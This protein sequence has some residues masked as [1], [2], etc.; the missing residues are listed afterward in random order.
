MKAPRKHLA[1][2]EQCSALTAY[3]LIFVFFFQ[4]SAAIAN[5]IIV[6]GRTKT[7]VTTQGAK[8]D[9]RT[10]TVRGASGFN[11]FREFDVH[12]NKTVDLHLP[13][14]TENL[15]NMVYDKRSN[16]EGA[17]NSV[18]DGS[19]GGNLI[20]VNPYGLIVGEQGSI[21]VGNLS[22][23]TP[24]P[25]FMNELINADGVISDARTQQ[26]M[27]GNI[28]LSAS[29]LITVKGQINAQDQVLLH[30]ASIDV[31]GRV[32]V[33]PAVQSLSPAF[34]QLVNVDAEQLGA[35]LV[36]NNGVIEIVA[37]NNIRIDGTLM[38]DGSDQSN[39]GSVVLNAGKDIELNSSTLISAKGQ[40]GLSD[41][42]VVLS[43]AQ[44]DAV[45]K[46]GAVIDV[47]SSAASGNGGFAEFSAKKSLRIENAEFAAHATN[48]KSGLVYLDPEKME[49]AGLKTSA[50]S[51]LLIEAD[52]LVVIEEGAIV[53]SRSVDSDHV[54]GASTADSG[55]IVIRAPNIV[56]E[57]QAQILAHSDSAAFE[58]GDVTLTNLRDTEVIDNDTLDDI[59]D[60]L[61]LEGK[62]IARLLN[63][64]RDA[65]ILVGVTKNAQSEYVEGTGAI[66]KGKDV[67]IHAYASDR[68][69]SEDRLFGKRARANVWLHNTQIE[70]ESI[71]VQAEA[72]T[73]LIPELFDE[74]LSVGGFE[75][76]P[77]A[78]VENKI[79]ALGIPDSAFY[80]KTEA[81]ADTRISGDNT[82]LHSTGEMSI[83]AQA[84]NAANPLSVG[85]YVG[86]EIIEAD[87]TATVSVE[88]QSVLRSDSDDFT[89]EASSDTETTADANVA[90]INKKIEIALALTEIES[91][92][93]VTLSGEGEIEAE[94][95][96]VSATSSSEVENTALANSSGGDSLVTALSISDVQSTAN[97]QANGDI[98]ADTLE[99]NALVEAESNTSASGGAKG[100]PGLSDRFTNLQNAS[101]ALLLDKAL[102]A[103]NFHNSSIPD[104]M[105]K[106]M[107]DGKFNVA[108]AITIADSN[109]NA[110]ALLGPLTHANVQNASNITAHVS[111]EIQIGADVASSSTGTA[112]GGAIT[113]GNYN[114]SSNA[115]ILG[116]A[117]LKAG[118]VNV[119]ATTEHPYPWDFDYRS[120]EE[121]YDKLTG[122]IAGM[123]FNGVASNKNK[124]KGSGAAASV[125]S[126]EYNSNANAAIEDGAIVRLVNTGEH[127][128]NVE[129][130]TDT[131][132]VMIAGQDPRSTGSNAIGGS[133]NVVVLGGEVLAS[134]G[135]ADISNDDG[136]GTLVGDLVNLDINAQTTNNAIVIT[137][138]GGT[139]DR[140][141][142]NGTVGYVKLDKQTKVYV[143]PAA[144]ISAQILSLNA[145]T[146][147]GIWNIA[148][149]F[150]KSGAAGVGVS[151]AINDA[152][153][154]TTSMIGDDDDTKPASASIHT[155][156]VA[157]EARAKGVL[158]T[159]S[160]A[161][162]IVSSSDEK[163]TGIYQKYKDTKKKVEG[164]LVSATDFVNSKRSTASQDGSGGDNSASSK[165]SPKPSYGVA[166]S[167]AASVNQ[168]AF[169]THAGVQ[170]AALN[171]TDLNTNAINSVDLDA[172]AG[173]ASL[174]KAKSSSTKTSAAFAGAFASNDMDNRT[175]ATIDNATIDDVNS[176][177]LQALSGGDQTAVGVGMAVNTSSSS[178][179][180]ASIAGSVS[181]THSN[182]QTTSELTGNS[183]MNGTANL[184]SS[185]AMTA[186]DQSQ[187]HAG[188]GSLFYG[189][190]GG[191]GAAITF[192]EIANQTQAIIDHATVQNLH[193]VSVKSI[194]AANISSGAAMAG[195]GSS[196]NSLA[197]SFVFNEINNSNQ[198]LIENGTV[199]STTDGD[200][201]ELVA[202]DQKTVSA[203]DAIIDGRDSDSD[204]DNNGSTLSLNNDE[205]N[206]IV[207]VAG[208]VQV[209]KNNV[210]VSLANNKISNT[211][212]VVVGISKLAADTVSAEAKTKTAINAVAVGV[213]GGTSS[214]A[215]NGSVALSEIN[216]QTNVFITPN[217]V[218][219]PISS[220]AQADTV[221]ASNNTSL[222]ASDESDIKSLAGNLSFSAKTAIGAAVSVSEISN[223]TKTQAQGVT[224]LHSESLMASAANDSD[225]E[226]L[227]ASGGGAGKVAI[228]AS[229]SVNEIDNQTIAQVSDSSFA[230][231]SQRLQ[232]IANDESDI[233]SLAGTINGAGKAAGGAAVSVNTIGNSTQ[234]WISDL[235]H[236]SISDLISIDAA[237]RANIDSYAVA[238]GG[239]GTAAFNGS[240]SSN[241]ISN[242]TESY[243]SNVQQASNSAA[244]VVASGD[245]STI[246]S[247]AGNVGFA[248]SAAVGASVAVNRISNTTSAYVTQNSVLKANNVMVN[249]F[250]SAETD[251]I[252]VGVSASAN[253]GIA[254]SVVVNINDSSVDAHIDG[255][256][257]VLAQHNVAVSAQSSDDI[258]VFAGALGIGVNGAGAGASV[259]VNQITSTTQAYISGAGTQ[260]NALANSATG[261]AV[262]NGISDFDFASEVSSVA[263]AAENGEDGEGSTD[264][265]YEK[266]ALESKLNA[267]TKATGVIVN[268]RSMQNVDSIGATAGVGFYAGI[269]ATGNVNILGGETRAYVN[270]ATLN[271]VAGA[272]D[273]QS[274]AVVAEDHTYTNAVVGAIGGGAAGIGAAVDTVIMERETLASIQNN[275][276]VNSE[277]NTKINAL[278]S[279]G[280]NSIAVGGA[281]GGAAL[282][283]SGSVLKF[284]AITTAQVEQSNL[285]SGSI[286]VRAH[287]QN[288]SSF[289]D[290]AAALASGSAGSGTFAVNI[291][292]NQTHATVN[293]TQATP[294]VLKSAGAVNVGAS[295]DIDNQSLVISFAGGAGAAGVAG[296][297]VVNLITSDTA[298]EVT[299]ATI[300]SD[301]DKVDSLTLSATDAIS[302]DSKAGAAG[303]SGGAGIG[304][305]ATVNIVKNRVRADMVNAD[306]VTENSGFVSLIAD[307]QKQADT[308]TAT[309]GAGLTVGI[310]GAALVNLFGAE[311]TG[312]AA[313]ELDNGGDG[314]LSTV[315]K[316]TQ[317][318]KSDLLEGQSSNTIT[319]QEL[320]AIDT[321][322]QTEVKS[323][324]SSAPLEGQFITRT[325]ITGA[326]SSVTT[327][328]L[329]LDASDQTS[330]EST[331]GGFAAG[332]VGFGGAFALTE[333]NNNLIAEVGQGVNVTASSVNLNAQ[334]DKVSGE[335]AVIDSDVYAGAAG[336]VGAGAAIALG[337]VNNTVLARY[338]GNLNDHSPS[339][340]KNA[341]VNI[342]AQDSS[343]VLTDAKGA[344]AG[345]AAA[346]IV[347]SESSKQSAVVAELGNGN[348]EDFT[349]LK[350]EA[351]TEGNIHTLAQAAAG[352]L[353]GSGAGASALAEESTEVSVEVADSANI[354]DQSGNVIVLAQADADVSADADGVAVA[355][356]LG[357]GVSTAEAIQHTQVKVDIGNNV[358]IDVNRLTA[359]AMLNQSNIHADA[360]AVGG[361]LLSGSSA[362]WAKSENLSDTSL[363]IGNLAS[364]MTQ[365]GLSLM[366]D[367]QAV[368]SASVD[369]ANGG[370]VAVGA[371]QSLVLNRA[372]SVVNIGDSTSLNNA[373][374][375]DVILA[376]KG[377]TSS[378][379][380]SVSGSG[381]VVSGVSTKATTNTATRTQVNINSDSSISNAND[382]VQ[383][384]A[385]QSNQINSKVD[386]INA[387]LV[388]ASGALASNMVDSEVGLSLSKAAIEAKRISL[389]ANN[390]TLKHWLG[391]VSQTS[392][393]SNATANVNSGSGGVVDAPAAR[394]STSILH[395]TNID[396]ADE[397]Q[398]LA[399]G[400][401]NS[402]SNTALAVDVLNTIQAKDKVVL[403]SGG[404]IAVAKSS[405]KI[406]STI[407]GGVQIDDSK[408]LAEYGQLALGTRNDVAIY[409]RA[410]ADTYGLAGA[411]E[412]ISVASLAGDQGITIGSGSELLADHGQLRLTAGQNSSGDNSS[413]DL[414]SKVNL[415]NKTAIPMDTDPDA[416][417]EVSLNSL[418]DVKSNA[419]VKASDDIYLIATDGDVNLYAYGLGKD[420]YRETLAKVGSAISNAF[421][422]GDVNFDITSSTETDNTN[423]T[424]NIDGSIETSIHRDQFIEI[425][426]VKNPASTD[427]IVDADGTVTQ[428]VQFSPDDPSNTKLQ[429]LY[430]KIKTS[431]EVGYESIERL[432][433]ADNLKQRMEKL[434]D[435][436]D[437]YA[438]DSVSFA[439]YGNEIDF[440]Q[441]QLVDM[442]LGGFD[443]KGDY[444]PGTLNTANKLSPKAQLQIVQDDN[445]AQRTDVNLEIDAKTADQTAIVGEIATV[446]A[447]KA[448][449]ERLRD[450]EQGKLDAEN[451]KDEADRD[452]DLI[453]EY[454]TEIVRLNDDIAEKD[455]ELGVLNTELGVV[456][457]ELAGLEN[458]KTSIQSNIDTLQAQIVTASDT[459]ISGPEAD[460][461][462]VDSIR[463]DLGNIIVKADNLTGTGSIKA[464]NDASISVSN[465]APIHLTLNDL[466]INDQ[467]GNITFNSYL[468]DG[469]NDVKAINKSGNAPGFTASNFVTARSDG[470]PEI[471]ITS[472]YNPTAAPYKSDFPATAPDIYFG[473]KDNEER[474]TIW[475]PEGRFTATSAAGSL[476]FEY[477]DV[478]A[479]TV[480]LAAENG[481]FV[482]SYTDN[483]YHVGGEPITVE[484]NKQTVGRGIFANGDILIS[485]RY[486]NINS[487]I[488]SGRE[489]WQLDI[490]SAP[491]VQARI[492]GN[493]SFVTESKVKS[494][495]SGQGASVTYIKDD[496]GKLVSVEFSTA[497]AKTYYDTYK[498]QSNASEFF[499]LVVANDDT[500][501][502]AFDASSD[503]IVV[504]GVEVS[505]GFIQLFGQLMNTSNDS[506]KLVVLDGYG[507]VQIDNQSG[508]NLELSNISTGRGV[509]GVIDI[510]D[511]VSVD[512]DDKPVLKRTI[513]ERLNGKVYQ[514]VNSGSATNVNESGLSYAPKAGMEFVLTTAQDQSSKFVYI[515]KGTSLFG[516]IK[517][518]EGE[519]KQYLVSSTPVGEPVALDGGRYLLENNTG[520]YTNVK[521]KTETKTT[522]SEFTYSE[523]SE[524]NWW[525]LCTVQNVTITARETRG[526]TVV[527]RNSVYAS[528]PI[529]I[530][531]IGD[532]SGGDVSVTSNFNSKVDIA[533]SI[534]NENGVTNILA[535]SGEIVQ[536]DETSVLQTGALNLVAKNDIYRDADATR[537]QVR[538][539][540][541]VNAVSADGLIR[542]EQQQGDLQVGSIVANNLVE[543]KS[544]GA[545]QSASNASQVKADRINLVASGGGIGESADDRLTIAAG[546]TTESLNDAFG[547]SIDAVDGI[548]LEQVASDIN[549]GGHLL[550]DKVKSATG[551]IDLKAHGTFIDNNPDERVD[552]A[553]QEQ[554]LAFW[555]STA[556]IGDENDNVFFESDEFSQ[557]IDSRDYDAMFAS[558]EY[559]NLST[560]GKKQVQ[561]LVSEERQNNNG[562][563]Q[564]WQ[565]RLEQA[566]PDTYNENYRYAASDVEIANLERQWAREGVDSSE[567][568]AR[569][570]QYEDDRT[571]QYH[572]LHDQVG[573]LNNGVYD[574]D[575]VYQLS[576]D[577]KQAL[578]KGSS[579]TEREL[580]LALSPGLIKDVTD[581]NPILKVA[582]VSGKS[583]RLESQSAGIG[584]QEVQIRIPGNVAVGTLSLSQ[585]LALASAE[586]GDIRYEDDDIIITRRRQVNLDSTDTVSIISH[587]GD[588]YVGSESDITIAEIVAD[589]EARIKA[590]GTIDTEALKGGQTAHVTAESIILE[591]AQGGI[592]NATNSVLIDLINGGSLIAR[593]EGDLFVKETNG[594]LSLD[595][596]YS[597]SEVY[598]ESDANIIDGFA[599]DDINLIG[600]GIYL[601]ANNGSIGDAANA[602]DIEAS[603]NSLLTA[604]ALHN[605]YLANHS[606]PLNIDSITAGNI[607]GLDVGVTG[608]AI[609]TEISAGK[610]V[611]ITGDGSLVLLAP[612]GVGSQ[613]NA[614]ENTEI[615]IEGNLL[616]EQ[617]SAIIADNLTL[618]TGGQVELADITVSEDLN[619]LSGDD[620]TLV[621]NSAIQTSGVSSIRS[622]GA[623]NSAAGSSLLSGGA[624]TLSALGSMTLSQIMAQ[625]LSVDGRSSVS[626]NNV[627]ILNDARISAQGDMSLNQITANTL[628]ADSAAAIELSTIAVT[629]GMTLVA[630]DDV[631]MAQAQVG[632]LD[633]TAGTAVSLDEVDVAAAAILASQGD[634]SLNQITANT[635]NADS[636]AAIEL[637]TIAVTEG[638]TLVAAD[639]VMMAQAQVG[640][641][642]VT[643]G[644]AVSLDEVDVAAAAILAS[645]GDMSLNQI[646]ANTLNADSAAAIELSTIAVTK[647]VTLVS[648]LTMEL[649]DL[650]AQSITATSQN[651]MNLTRV[652]IQQQASFDAS[653]DLAL[654]TVS[655][656]NADILGRAN[657]ALTDVKVVDTANVNSAQQLSMNDV[658][659]AS[660][661]ANGGSTIT[662]VNATISSD[663]TINAQDNMSLTSVSAGQLMLDGKASTAMQDI[664]VQNDV[665]VTTVNVLELANAISVGT[666]ATVSASGIKMQQGSNM[667]VAKNAVLTSA[668]SIE[669]T[670]LNVGNNLMVDVTG[671]MNVIQ[672]VTV[673]DSLNA[674]TSGDVRFNAGAV[675]TSASDLTITAQGAILGAENSELTSGE[676][677]TLLAQGDIEI[678]QVSSHNAEIRGQSDVTV[679][680]AS[681][682]NESLIDVLGDLTLINI[683][684]EELSVTSEANAQMQEIAVGNNFTADI[685]QALELGSTTTV[686][687][688]SRVESASL[689]MLQGSSFESGNSSEFT[690]DTAASLTDVAVAGQLMISTGTDLLLRNSI[691]AGADLTANSQRAFELDNASE[692]RSI[693]A[694]SLSSANDMVTASDAQISSGELMTVSVGGD[695]QM[696]QVTANQLDV[697]GEG[698]IA[699]DRVT[700]ALG[701]SIDSAEDLLIE[702]LSSD[703]LTIVGGTDV[704][705]Q[706][707]D[708]SHAI[709][710]VA[711]NVI[712]INDTLDA[713]TSIEATATRLFM[714]PDSVLNA[715]SD[716][717]VNTAA[718]ASFERVNIGGRFDVT[719]GSDVLL[720]QAVTATNDVSI[721]ALGNFVMANTATLSSGEQ[722]IIESEQSVDIQE[723]VTTSTLTDAVVIKAGEHIAG[724]D[725]SALHIS[726]VNGGAELTAQTDIGAADVALLT[727]VQAL[728]AESATGNIFVHNTGDV[729]ILL[730]AGTAIEATVVGHMTSATLV[731]AGTTAQ[732]VASE[733]MMLNQLEVGQSAML[734]SA[735]ITANITQLDGIDA[736]LAL[737]IQQGDSAVEQTQL[738]VTTDNGLVF[739]RFWSEQVDVMSHHREL[740]LEGGIFE[741]GARFQTPDTLLVVD[742][743]EVK[744]QV[745]PDVQVYSKPKDVEFVLEGRQLTT[746]NV[747][748]GTR[749]SHTV[750]TPLGENVD[751]A[752]YTEHQTQTSSAHHQSRDNAIEVRQN[753]LQVR[754]QRAQPSL[755]LP[756]DT[757]PENLMN[758]DNEETDVPLTYLPKAHDEN[759]LA[760][761]KNQDARLLVASH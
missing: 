290:F 418:L 596:V 583:V 619:V 343:S 529:A 578:L 551:D 207:G 727:Q 176:V 289:Y 688:N 93:S 636:A 161:G 345:A 302:I 401:E 269:A 203:L 300:G 721:N 191:V 209:G 67:D 206:S 387:S 320:A 396:V 598:L 579:W 471:T 540:G 754:Q 669:L 53:S 180:S 353:L 298:A 175:T 520:S 538:A 210:G 233:G 500:I 508:Y 168:V 503:T 638:M 30:G 216:N 563:S 243:L 525:T 184:D 462:E 391:A 573:D 55:D 363:A 120:Y 370:I 270:N 658:N 82:E 375:G 510:T 743:V 365:N 731:Q 337:S 574:Q 318:S 577:D 20:F 18:K 625:Q 547:V 248:G 348:I 230:M 105:F 523:R 438:A 8:T 393:G 313:D 483:F 130:Q 225:I 697:E 517:L 70:A 115:E 329:N 342:L 187:V 133:V 260:V 436:Q 660:L 35:A 229:V 46:S 632:A 524:C 545:I 97:V 466:F 424:V 226:T 266:I 195:G 293:G 747:V 90:G 282:A 594:D 199:A 146:D 382:D 244:L 713:G 281:G 672:S 310:G 157:I 131:N 451:A 125:N 56:V 51:E 514:T 183:E 444:I 257:N 559:Q 128:L 354:S 628:N 326:G 647:A 297:A 748:I 640:A 16:I 159:I 431:S 473:S 696:S 1:L 390:T 758:L 172:I 585:K 237:N 488:Q 580:T 518:S 726:A 156:E 250:S 338:N 555:D 746:E 344:A 45:M 665:T 132:L 380:D 541:Q 501:G 646:T 637:S 347:V 92:A 589:K 411:P 228:G 692:L 532:E 446:D 445:K 323:S 539:S 17:L 75:L 324:A 477:A 581:S 377:T 28:P 491:T 682:A 519:L 346:G 36:N 151:V 450:I 662:I 285:D 572:T 153:V 357:V 522:A 725:S 593:S 554:L 22:V 497:F 325:S 236:L 617:E 449:S 478:L 276:T 652:D 255:D 306:V 261:L 33:N 673:G 702:E 610:D 178:S 54:N 670:Q 553:T 614:G 362:T 171:T 736:P 693:G 496:D 534:F 322:G 155:E 648:L 166:V 453:S 95:L 167:G 169:E 140:I 535:G 575:Y 330:A 406:V 591:S 273:R 759:G 440:L 94:N 392:D 364:L 185:L 452:A 11:A 495:A 685:A 212:N 690:T 245:Y 740:I 403:N 742:N 561:S 372:Q 412:G 224:L 689:E 641:L 404:A 138:A 712:E 214:L 314:T 263:E 220:G 600:N 10:E 129:A 675:V 576:E 202:I 615:D 47:S 292:N 421:G 620:L 599:N 584:H 378:L 427:M 650:M 277:G 160:I 674:Q 144:D 190:K 626:L 368:Q 66:I 200:T 582:N 334:A 24:T 309:A 531:F 65:Q 513:Y 419:A 521:K 327:G 25:E 116:G 145:D 750:N 2:S 710:L 668:D 106:Q 99:V 119:S 565:M 32:A 558:S 686:G 494:L 734:D 23:S 9:V 192:T 475:N 735:L 448:E 117:E 472:T 71:N 433:L 385:Q 527:N 739:E 761:L 284:D 597:R 464:P 724:S 15:I 416:R 485:A 19:I 730:D 291:V 295:S 512:A 57:Q 677:L 177:Q 239:A 434:E 498:S 84:I 352:G 642:D 657:M 126:I 134:V 737:V 174:T 278:S 305:G 280:A 59:I 676:L 123:L 613:I 709:A 732:L 139:A 124:A 374:A 655:A 110:S 549:I 359:K 537:V 741:T 601:T 493:D 723:I 744:R 108:G 333:V 253:A 608:T 286:D 413:I 631:M 88:D 386:G 141:G 240:A 127:R 379:A 552:D 705:L 96:T 487:T 350:I 511:I 227:S 678:E 618:E 698:S 536:S 62:D 757:K 571:S 463:V 505:G 14:G 543:L 430:Y 695:L 211:T 341:S 606:V 208:L 701:A 586:R 504:D 89:I 654:T 443:D 681:F 728:Q 469:I 454:E 656:Q 201:I 426:Y 417:A 645:Q 349:Q 235:A 383:L 384:L 61:G 550:I 258:D 193:A 154:T 502:A 34:T 26:L 68:F 173:S 621:Q 179:K 204:I 49:I 733:S 749:S 360:L 435:L 38:A 489:M 52:E 633:V 242:V 616:M 107:K 509:E 219:A 307:S 569:T 704:S 605:V 294:L 671:D 64:D 715:G 516:F 21:N 222:M 699:L 296:M 629:E 42:G 231:P 152:D 102:Q 72:D 158:D 81:T 371:N 719:A 109:H 556:L 118:D 588:V 79:D 703:Q 602:V 410:A 470:D 121:V 274:V 73:S 340:N 113:V 526:Q 447:D 432:G 29:G 664:T 479:G 39:A 476:I 254:G 622:L 420:I 196:T 83:A 246:E 7:S 408:V 480:E 442:G 31:S 136:T 486:L 376:A 6:D 507:Q 252:A 198:V 415:W 264:S 321:K 425:T 205:G 484:G 58:A 299:D 272:N 355:G 388:G 43:L 460:F 279:Q 41:G 562:Y 87:T 429:G 492:D 369:A 78:F 247:L 5:N 666:D 414:K 339:L 48:G 468:V 317:G 409:A 603:R 100:K 649:S 465:D 592:G 627:S 251:T 336:I 194:N 164:Y 367:S 223:Q 691:S 256:S 361:G 44:N 312:D 402:Q 528:H 331:V 752:R 163:S 707:I 301:A 482:Q 91:T 609:H 395:A 533:G 86:L 74:S 288:Q 718:D 3:A 234:A 457:V 683:A 570:T 467:G 680:N 262:T 170:N 714:N 595:T 659:A 188:G 27:I 405:S 181:L 275:A 149:G 422:G 546:Y 186:Y 644:T 142:I 399:S 544:A 751:L 611:V 80:V 328:T 122:G 407:N 103:L 213:G 381:G 217:R 694:M 249:G 12:Q 394:S 490:G 98:N 268:A 530:D 717:A 661:L 238:G 700:I 587:F 332:A 722:V 437:Q 663:A 259:S 542:I 232:V 148:G 398:L 143:D 77:N 711:A 456:N 218:S 356:G 265:D 684:A 441:R 241:E 366:T 135:A 639:D 162:A 400:D 351:I 461:M 667:N 271:S 373:N 753:V 423:A 630:A 315:D 358:D 60:S 50:G 439:A 458:R 474:S 215:A 635:L 568:S 283:A 607:V 745:E 624:M 303:V 566:D 515:K 428:Y 729:E 643:A 653:G 651:T 182:N 389:A 738:D 397:S 287:G 311:L 335:A 316:F 189:G 455:N 564:Y 548:Y 112:L 101:K 221:I 679:E 37:Q 104:K 720:N 557:W 590:A 4:P 499:R 147:L 85:F 308:I 634:M 165:D 708:V 560:N 114:N 687:F 706:T 755:A 13:S 612:S 267:D 567:F 760:M 506:G 319:A 716:V 150:I 459:P 197:G 623:M 63:G 111:D 304:A 69:V 481:D 137:E 40:G 756:E 76:D 604:T